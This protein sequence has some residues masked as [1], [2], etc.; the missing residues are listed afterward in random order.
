MCRYQC[1]W[2]SRPPAGSELAMRCLRRDSHNHPF[3]PATAILHMPVG[4]A[5]SLPPPRDRIRDDPALKWAMPLGRVAGSK[6][7]LSYSVFFAAAI[8]VA[9]VLSISARPENADLPRAAA[10]G[11][12]FWIA[13][14]IAQLLVHFVVPRALKV[15]T[16]EINVGLVGVEASPRRWSATATL[17][18]SISTIAS[19]LLLG[20][21][22]RLVEGGFQMPVLSRPSSGPWA[23]PGIGFGTHDSLWRSAAWLCWAQAVFQL[24]PLPKTMGR[25]I[26]GSLASICGSRLDLALQAVIFRRCL[27]AVALLTLVLAIFVMSQDDSVALAGQWPLLLLLGV[28]L[29]ASS[30][31]GDVID[32]LMAFESSHQVAAGDV[33]GQAAKGS[34]LLRRIHSSIQNRKDRIRLRQAMDKEHREAVDAKRLDDILNRLH[35]EGLDSLS[36]QDRRILERVS[37]NLRKQRQADTE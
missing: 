35:R 30:R 27:S 4:N 6:I 9:V 31:A 18:V 29:W 34:G 13:G 25:Q 5:P 26:F 19:L 28:L 20:C 22:F 23:A 3:P 37:E 24:Y 32:I 14:W 33:G 1:L 11:T 21:F 12:A 15:Q 2:E 7:A 36:D 17:V 16:S 8:L 10:L